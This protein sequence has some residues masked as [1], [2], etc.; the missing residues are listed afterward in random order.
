MATSSD[1]IISCKCGLHFQVIWTELPEVPRDDA[2]CPSCQRAHRFFG[3]VE[4]ITIIQDYEQ[5]VEINYKE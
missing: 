1:C 3:K 4:S 5:I 2:F